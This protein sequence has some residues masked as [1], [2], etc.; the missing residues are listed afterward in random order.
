[1]LNNSAFQFSESE[2]YFNIEKVVD[3]MFF[4]SSESCRQNP[5]IVPGEKNEQL[6]SFE[7][8]LESDNIT[9]KNTQKTLHALAFGPENGI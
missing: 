4:L 5:N 6:K 1:M 2:N 3:N 9:Y 8:Q 7:I